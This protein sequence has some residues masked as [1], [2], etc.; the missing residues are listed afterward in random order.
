MSF[1]LGGSKQKGTTTGLQSA[2][3]KIDEKG[4]D[5]LF[6]TALETEG[7]ADILGADNASGIYN[8]TTEKQLAGEFVARKA[9][10]VA[11]RNTTITTTTDSTQK[12]KGGK[13]GIGTVLCTHYMAT[14]KLSIDEHAKAAKHASDVLSAAHLRGYHWWACPVVEMIRA[15]G[16]RAT[17]LHIIFY[18]ITKAWVGWL[19]GSRKTVLG[20][21]TWYIMR[22]ACYV[23]GKTV[24]REK[25]EWQ[26]LYRV[27]KE[28]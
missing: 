6:Q 16:L 10:E 1:D 8:S 15:G 7:L 20:A 17:I 14:G 27:A 3:T 25:Q 26:R 18:P 22:P 21:M 4:L 13:V 24:A 19:S 12:Q 5:Y 23:F 28:N 9:G 2:E 11:A